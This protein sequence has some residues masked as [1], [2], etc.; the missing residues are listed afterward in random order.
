MS[1]ATSLD[2]S[3]PPVPLKRGG[4]TLGAGEAA[5]ADARIGLG[6]AAAARVAAA[7]TAAGMPDDVRVSVEPPPLE[8]LPEEAEEE[9]EPRGQDVPPLPL[10][11]QHS[12]APRRSQQPNGGR[13]GSRP[14]SRAVS[15]MHP[16]GRLLRN[17]SRQLSLLSAGT[18]RTGAPAPSVQELVEGLAALPPPPGSGQGG[19][20]ACGGGGERRGPRPARR[21][22]VETARKLQQLERHLRKNKLR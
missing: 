5:A 9:G 20:A 3:G 7:A 11:P 22:D 19:G 14:P 17:D 16:G 21:I 4:G 6:A 10:L 12:P 13:L 2:G 15:T 18:V 1:D 8:S